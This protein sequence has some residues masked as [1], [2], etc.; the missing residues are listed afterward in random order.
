[1]RGAK[2]VLAVWLGVAAPAVAAPNFSGLWSNNSLTQL[3]RPDDFKTLVVTEADA[4]TYEKKHLG[5]PPEI[6]NDT[7]GGADSEW[8]DTDIGL[9][10]IR[11]QIRSS[12]LV[13]PADGQLPFTA[14]ATASQ[15]ARSKR[16]KVDFDNPESRD[17]SERCLATDAAGPPM[18]NG[19]YNDNYQFV[20][21]PGQL[22]MLAE[23][24][25]ALRIVRLAPD[26][27]HP[28]PSLR[29]AM[30]DSIGRWD[31]DV[32]V[33][34]TTNFIATD[35]GYEAGPADDMRV[36]ERLSRTSPT[37]LHYEFWVH[38]PA[39]FTQP[40]QGELTFHATKGPLYEFACHEGNYALP[41]TL[42]AG[43]Q[44]EARARAAFAKVSAGTSG[45]RGPLNPRPA[46]A[47]PP[48]APAWSPAR[49]PEGAA[50]TSP[51]TPRP[52]R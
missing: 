9:M 32:L 31:G 27:R 39:E 51:R 33:I 34:E 35:I 8:W 17:R 6:P 36:V 45:L 19:G 30:G 1:M 21:T 15:K 26:A 14:K 20:Q 5:K 7:I 3:E 52:A 28:P 18:L 47:S 42:S 23:H 44:A 16:R 41:S 4:L 22:A 2:L 12:E 48:P 49:R 40:W 10:R 13:S 43:R 46:V 37:E 25:A 50:R 11:G 29:F 24:M 38:A